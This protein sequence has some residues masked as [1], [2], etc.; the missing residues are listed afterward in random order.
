MRANLRVYMISMKYLI[1]YLEAFK[2][3]VL[4]RML[5]FVI[6]P[7]NKLIKS[8]AAK[9]NKKT[10]LAMGCPENEL[11]A[12]TITIYSRLLVP[13]ISVIFV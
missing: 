13:F 2:Q 9:N 5:K 12:T 3:F 7:V 6:K 1:T 11:I 4:S 8:F 10:R